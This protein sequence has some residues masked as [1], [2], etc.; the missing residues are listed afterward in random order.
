MSGAVVYI[1]YDSQRHCPLCVL[2]S[3]SVS[4]VW[5]F[6]DAPRENLLRPTQGGLIP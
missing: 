3:V 1:G 5:L 2:H 6:Y 4:I